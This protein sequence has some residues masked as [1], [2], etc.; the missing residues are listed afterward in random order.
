MSAGMYANVQAL[1]AHVIVAA[2]RLIKFFEAAIVWR[3]A[4]L[5]V[6]ISSVQLSLKTLDVPIFCLFRVWYDHDHD[7]DACVRCP[8]TQR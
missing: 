5:F 3:C 4:M 6:H 8:E 1:F 2:E 7:H